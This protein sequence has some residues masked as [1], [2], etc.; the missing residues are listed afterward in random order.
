VGSFSSPA[1]YL[2]EFAGAA[3]R[4]SAHASA[5]GIAIKR[6]YAAAEGT[7][8]YRALIDRLWPRGMTKERAAL[9]AWLSDLAPSTALRVWFHRDVKRWPEFARRYRAELRAHAALLQTLRQRARRQRVT[10]LSAARDAR[11]NHAMVLRGVLLRRAPQATP[12]RPALRA[13]SAVRGR[14]LPRTRGG[15]RP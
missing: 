6:I 7:D 15:S 8:G 10:L 11:L 9:D 4:V 14:I 5:R 13:R 3:G 1:C 12:R 2:H